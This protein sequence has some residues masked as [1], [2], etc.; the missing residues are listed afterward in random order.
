[1]GSEVSDFDR[2]DGI[3]NLTLFVN[4]LVAIPIVIFKDQRPISLSVLHIFVLH[5]W[6]WCVHL[7]SSDVC[8]GLVTYTWFDP[9]KW[10]WDSL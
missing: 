6:H 10:V 8:G 4:F 3:I 2:L 7:N 5:C 1:M 9:E